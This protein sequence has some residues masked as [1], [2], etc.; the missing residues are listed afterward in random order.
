LI[1]QAIGAYE[2]ALQVR[3]KEAFPLQWGETMHNLKIAKEAL[4]D[5]K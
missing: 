3:T 5:M 4:E 2:L 1:H